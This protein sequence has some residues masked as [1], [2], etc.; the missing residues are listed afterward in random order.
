MKCFYSLT[1]CIE[2]LQSFFHCKYSLLKEHDLC[3]AYTIPSWSSHSNFWSCPTC[4]QSGAISRNLCY[5]TLRADFSPYSLYPELCQLVLAAEHSYTENN[6]AVPVTLFY[7]P[8]SGWPFANIPGDS[9]NSKV[10]QRPAI[11]KPSALYWRTET[12]PC[13]SWPK[14]LV[15]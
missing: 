11:I 2:F 4:F 8:D 6:G 13:P 7:E 14:E 12:F 9:R 3:P 15:H 5:Y 10:R 1:A